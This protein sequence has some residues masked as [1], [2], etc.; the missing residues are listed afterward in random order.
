MKSSLYKEE[1]MQL[2]HW[3]D[4]QTLPHLVEDTD[5]IVLRI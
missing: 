2:A 4:V 3:K 1:G 5:A